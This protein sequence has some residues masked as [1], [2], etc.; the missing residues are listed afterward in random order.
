MNSR[1]NATS[2]IRLRTALTGAAISLVGFGVFGCGAIANVASSIASSGSRQDAQAS[3]QDLLEGIGKSKAATATRNVELTDFEL[4]SEVD[5]HFGVI[6]GGGAPSYNEIALEKNVLYFQRSLTELGLSPEL[7]TLFFASGNPLEPTVR[8]LDN[9]GQ[10]QFKAAE[11]PNLDGGATL[12]NTYSWFHSL[13]EAQKACPAFLYVTGHGAYNPEDEDNNWIILWEE[14][15]VSV[16]ELTKLL[17]PLPEDQ[18]FVTMMAQCYSGSFANMIY[19]NGDPTQPVALQ[20]R[21]GFF[22]TVASRPS[23]GCTPAVNEAD[24]KDYSSSFFAGLTGRDRVGNTAPSADYDQDGQV[25]YAEAHAF[26]KV[27]EK[28]TDWPISTVEAWLQRQ[29]ADREIAEILALPIEDLKAIARPEQQYVIASLA[30]ITEFDASQSYTANQQRSRRPAEN[31]VAEAYWV[32]LE[33]E[34]INVGA[35]ATVRETRSPDQ[36]AILDKI[37]DCESGTP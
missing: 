31:T 22:A 8:Y 30:D 16:Q 28:T 19:E 21:C 34:L 36:I 13:A 14:A 5:T 15:F 9:D 12:T 11:I 4:S 1:Q 24:Y 26:A 2:R 20:T 10:E 33:M 27:D 3:L 18:P 17:E 6:A 25:S 29:V 32:R 37:I 23:V 35:E 7:A